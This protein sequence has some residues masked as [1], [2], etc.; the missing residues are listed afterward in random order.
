MTTL[1]LDVLA[2]A[3]APDVPWSPW[4]VAALL[5]VRVT[6]VP[7]TDGLVSVALRNPAVVY[8][9]P[10][11]CSAREEYQL[12]RSILSLCRDWPDALIDVEA[13]FLVA[14]RL[15]DRGAA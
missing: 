8:L 1:D 11:L 15:A 5:G 9:R 7:M 13:A 10:G 3:T 4:M 14:P 2:A 6:R 12:T